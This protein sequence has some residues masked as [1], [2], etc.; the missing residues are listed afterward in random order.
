MKRHR[1]LHLHFTPTSAS[2]L[3]LVER[4]F[5]LIA[6]DAM[7]RG[8]FKGVADLKAAVEACLEHHYAD[9]RP[10]IQAAP[11]DEIFENVGRGRQVLVSVH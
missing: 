9:P 6:E 10:L 8:V 3:N 7:C 4:L 11:A 5:G 1:R 2:R